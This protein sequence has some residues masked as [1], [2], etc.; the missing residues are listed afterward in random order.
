MKKNKTQTEKISGRFSAA[1][2]L[3][4]LLFVNTLAQAQYESFFGG[5]SWEYNICHLNEDIIDKNIGEYDSNLVWMTC[6]TDTY[7][8]RRSNYSI[9]DEEQYFIN[10]NQYSP[11]IF[12][13]EDIIN[14]RLYAKYSESGEDFLLCDL[15]LSV[16][17]TFFCAVANSMENIPMVVDSITYENSR[18][19][20]HLTIVLDY[21]YFFYG[22]FGEEHEL[23]DYN[24]SLRFMEGVG[25]IYGI[26]LPHSVTTEL[27][28]LLCMHKDDTL[29]YRTHVDLG[30]FQENIGGDVPVHSK[31]SIRVFPNPA[32]H[33]LTLDVLEEDLI[34]GH[35]SIRDLAG[36]E[37]FQK[38]I[39]D[40]ISVI[41]LTNLPTGGY[42]LTFTNQGKKELK[43]II[44]V[45]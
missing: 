38:D 10:D 20:I 34:D 27:D 3:M 8:Y 13:K 18:K 30:C 6:T 45:K 36:R 39:Q 26:R 7:T 5:E 22:C 28:A 40:R 19:T 21:F 23:M 37:C 17:D 41:P 12:L 2:A 4:A 42:L 29:C 15:S 16:G 1:L 33:F 32:Q 9:I 25:P 11:R 24:V 35:V 44:I 31:S 43:K 14:G